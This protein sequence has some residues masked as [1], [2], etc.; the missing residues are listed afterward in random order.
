MP[1]KNKISEI[2]IY[3]LQFFFNPTSKLAIPLVAINLHKK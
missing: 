1:I 3:N 2:R